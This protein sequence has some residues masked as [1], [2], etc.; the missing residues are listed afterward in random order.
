MAQTSTSSSANRAVP[1]PV[2]AAAIF[3]CVVAVLFIGWRSLSGS[4]PVSR[5]PSA[6]VPLRAPNPWIVEKA[7]ESNGD[8]NRLSQSDQMKLQ[9][10]T[11][12]HGAQALAAATR[13]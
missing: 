1:W 6:L 11:Q 5:G 4:T 9:Q 7:R 10:L 13:N 12:G 2:T 8:I 3:L